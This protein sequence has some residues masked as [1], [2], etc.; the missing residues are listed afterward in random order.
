MLDLGGL[1]IAYARGSLCVCL[2][3]GVF[4]GWGLGLGF[5]R[6]VDGLDACNCYIE[7]H[8][9]FMLRDMAL[10]MMGPAV[11]LRGL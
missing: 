10:M 7:G 9:W 1:C 3:N 4:G 8:F 6:E 11:D 2:C 5:G